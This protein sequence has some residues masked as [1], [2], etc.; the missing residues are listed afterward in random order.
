M[1]TTTSNAPDLMHPGVQADLKQYL[2]TASYARKETRAFDAFLLSDLFG[3]DVAEYPGTGQH[4]Y[5]TVNGFVCE[6]SVAI[7]VLFYCAQRGTYALTLDAVNA[8]VEVLTRTVQELFQETGVVSR[9]V[10]SAFA[11][12]RVCQKLYNNSQRD[13]SPLESYAGQ[14]VTTFILNGASIENACMPR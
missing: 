13:I 4:G 12:Y 11:A 14:I 3:F 8:A 2:E 9:S 1:T 6:K 10:Y 5:V 7:D